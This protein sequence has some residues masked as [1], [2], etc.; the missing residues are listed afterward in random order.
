MDDEPDIRNLMEMMLSMLNYDV[1]T[2]AHG[3]E[4]L[5]AHEKAIEEGRRFNIAVMDLTVP[6]G[7]GGAET[8][9]RLR[10]KDTAIRAVVASGSSDNPVV[11]RHQ[12]YG[13]DR[14]LPKPYVMDDLMRVLEALSEP[15]R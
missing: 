6:H 2:T 8:I 1:V 15:R 5:A 12:E 4:A 3:E 9:K 11:A 10:Q 14:V 7:M 13:F